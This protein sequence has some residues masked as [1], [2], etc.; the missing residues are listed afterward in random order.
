MWD[1]LCSFSCSGIPWIVSRD[2]NIIRS[3]DEHAGGLPGPR[4]AMNE[5][6][7]CINSCGL[8]DW[9]IEGRQLSWCDGSKGWRG[10]G[11]SLTACFLTILFAVKFREVSARFL[12]RR[13]SDHAPILVQFAGNLKGMVQRLFIFRTCGFHMMIF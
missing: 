3:D 1:H 13:T 9:K 10:V 5:F 8:L 7:S 2:F 11:Q 6:N 4:N 12:S